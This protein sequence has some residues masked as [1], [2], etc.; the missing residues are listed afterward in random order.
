MSAPP[1]VKPPRP[2]PAAEGARN[3]TGA[4]IIGDAAQLD[5]LRATITA[6]L[7]LKGYALH[8]LACGGYVIASAAGTRYAADLRAASAFAEALE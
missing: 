7:A 2:G 8:E 3:N 4:S 6:R 1:K 5:K